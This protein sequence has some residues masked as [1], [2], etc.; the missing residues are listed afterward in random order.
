M[1]A[2]KAAETIDMTPTWA[3]LLPALLALA[4][5]STAAGK[6]TAREEFARMAQAADNWNANA[7]ALLD[8]LRT[9]ERT[10]AGSLAARGYRHGECVDGWEQAARDELAALVPIRAALAPFANVK[11][12]G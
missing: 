5:G 10:I 12:E 1:N 11:R 9:A 8:A 6:K 7:G 3:G 2:E 4:E